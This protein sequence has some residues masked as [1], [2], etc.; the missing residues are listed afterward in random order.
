MITRA[1]LSVILS[2][3]FLFSFSLNAQQSP[4]WGDRNFAS[5]SPRDAIGTCSCKAKESKDADLKDLSFWSRDIDNHPN[6]LQYYNEFR[7]RNLA[8]YRVYAFPIA[9]GGYDTCIDVHAGMPR[10]CREQCEGIRTLLTT[11][12]FKPN[13][14]FSGQWSCMTRNADPF[15]V[16]SREMDLNY[17]KQH[18]SEWENTDSFAL[19]FPL[20]GTPVPLAVDGMKGLFYPFKDKEEIEPFDLN[21]FVPD[22]T[23]LK[24]QNGMNKLEAFILLLLGTAMMAASGPTMQTQSCPAIIAPSIGQPDRKNGPVACIDQKNNDLVNKHCK[25]IEGNKAQCDLPESG[26]SLIELTPEGL[27]V[28]PLT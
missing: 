22:E 5:P 18:V 10:I 13:L 11:I 3:T 2:F 20:L 28:I 23:V 8:A 16:P 17:Q 27:L 4:I 1:I 24:P 9:F 25:S 6:A 12:G 14:N 21:A 19:A 26:E 7:D 15:F